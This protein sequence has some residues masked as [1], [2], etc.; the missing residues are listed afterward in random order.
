MGHGADRC[1]GR[2]DLPHP[3]R[4]IS[5]DFARSDDGCAGS[6]GAFGWANFEHGCIALGVE[7]GITV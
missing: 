3:L 6:F 2:V 7:E 1:R 5:H 4:V